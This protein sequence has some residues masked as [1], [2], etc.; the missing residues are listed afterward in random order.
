MVFAQPHALGEDN[1][2]AVQERGLC[3]I[4]LSNRLCRGRV[5]REFST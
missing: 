3:D 2:Q 1:A 4:R 5:M